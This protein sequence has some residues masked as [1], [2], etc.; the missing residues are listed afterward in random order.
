VLSS[1][2][3]CSAAWVQTSRSGAF[4]SSG[5]SHAGELDQLAAHR[6]AHI[7][8]SPR[9][10]TV[11]Q[12]LHA[13]VEREL[14]PPLV[15][16]ALSAAHPGS[17]G[18]ISQPLLGQQ[19]DTC[20]HDPAM[21]TSFL[22]GRFDQLRS[23]VL[24]NHDLDCLRPRHAS[25]WVAAR[26]AFIPDPRKNFWRVVLGGTRARVQC[27]DGAKFGQQYRAYRVALESFADY[28][29]K[30]N[31]LK[32]H[33]GSDEN[34]R[35]FER[36]SL[37]SALRNGDG[38]E[39]LMWRSVRRNI[40]SPWTSLLSRSPQI[41]ASFPVM[42]R[43]YSW[44]CRTIA[45][46]GR[47]EQQDRSSVNS[48]HGKQSLAPGRPLSPVGKRTSGGG[49]GRCSRAPIRVFK[50]FRS[51]CSTWSDARSTM[52]GEHDKMEK[53]DYEDD[54]R[55]RLPPCENGPRNLLCGMCYCS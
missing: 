9:P 17:D 39:S 1:R 53:G 44:P 31:S 47:I 35:P 3:A 55:A 43:I 22:R 48:W 6:D 10:S 45:Y 33:L 20:P 46:F 42:S 27:A 38:R 21:H 12:D 32:L 19:H 28:A 4:S 54:C 8:W 18:G 5:L 50:P 37:P 41:M 25:E 24:G 49:Q 11:L 51:C 34:C 15:D 7:A 29:G 26:A 13:W 40:D 23:H 2:A 16:R 30:N 52:L 14:R 36:R